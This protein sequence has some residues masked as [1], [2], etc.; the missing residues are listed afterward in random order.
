[1]LALSRHDMIDSACVESV[2]RYISTGQFLCD[3]YTVHCKSVL[4]YLNLYGGSRV[5][6]VRYTAASASVDGQVT[7]C[8]ITQRGQVGMVVGATTED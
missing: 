4:G 8:Q 5:R 1:M 7:T 6:I 3:L 2:H